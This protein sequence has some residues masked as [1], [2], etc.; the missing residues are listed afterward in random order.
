MSRRAW[1]SRTGKNHLGDHPLLL[2]LAVLVDAKSVDALLV[3]EGID[4]DLRKLLR[5]SCCLLN[6]SNP[7]LYALRAKGE[8]RGR[9]PWEAGKGLNGSECARSG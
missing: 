2:R 5:A 1:S 4:D 8:D 7:F 9:L 6:N 3:D